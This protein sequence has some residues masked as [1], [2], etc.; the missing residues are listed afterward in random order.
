MCIFGPIFGIVGPNL[1]EEDF[2]Y[3]SY[4]NHIKD[5]WISKHWP[6]MGSNKVQYWAKS[7]PILDKKHIWGQSY[8]YDL[9]FIHVGQYGIS[10]VNVV[11]IA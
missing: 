11:T 6:N 9:I 2:L 7:G 4:Q 5:S 10:G 8:R 3:F 1:P